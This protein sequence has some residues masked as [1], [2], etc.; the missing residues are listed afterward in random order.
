MMTGSFTCQLSEVRK[1]ESMMTHFLGLDDCPDEDL[2]M[3][4]RQVMSQVLELA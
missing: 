4:G 3:D 2:S 1:E